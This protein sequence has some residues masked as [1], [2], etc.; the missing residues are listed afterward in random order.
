MLFG[1][2]MD[3]LNNNWHLAKDHE[4][5]VVTEFELQLW[6]VHF[7]FLHWQEK[8]EKNI[9]GMDL[10]AHELAILHII[11]MKDKPKT[12]TDIARLL[13]RNDIHTIRYS[14]AKLLKIGFIEKVKATKEGSK[15][16]SFQITAIG[17]KNTDEYA[18]MRK[19]ILVKMFNQEPNLN[20]DNIVKSFIKIKSIY[21]EAERAVSSWEAERCQNIEIADPKS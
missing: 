20:L 18:K 16:Y 13:N 11:R 9:S 15:N 10:T 3:K 21:D 2:V 14:I 5:N 1:A 7:A 8:C 12:V 19:A 6:R 17:I 4:E